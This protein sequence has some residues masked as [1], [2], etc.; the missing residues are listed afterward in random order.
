MIKPGVLFSD[1]NELMAMRKLNW[2]IIESNL[3]EAREQ[4]EEIEGRIGK[5]P[6]ISEVEFQ[7]MMQHAYHHLNFAWNARHAPMRRYTHLTEE[8]FC[9]WGKLPE[10]LDFRDDE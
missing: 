3:R 7:I 8:D 5:G 10:D 1:P 6:R 2:T 9:H 4:L